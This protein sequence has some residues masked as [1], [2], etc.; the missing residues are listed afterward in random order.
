MRW[1][2]SVGVSGKGDDE[3]GLRQGRLPAAAVEMVITEVT[4]AMTVVAAVIVVVVVV[5]PVVKMIQDEADP[6][7]RR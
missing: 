2:E 6:G 5:R 3:N 7:L 1:Y 4:T